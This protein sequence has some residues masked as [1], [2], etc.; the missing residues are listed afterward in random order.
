MTCGMERP[1]EGTVALHDQD[2]TTWPMFRR[3]LKGRWGISRFKCFAKLSVE[4]DLNLMI[5]LQGITGKQTSAL[6]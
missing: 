5:E 2:V 6:Q 4:Q 1:D 3:A